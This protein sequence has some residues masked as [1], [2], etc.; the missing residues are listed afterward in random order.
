MAQKWPATPEWRAKLRLAMQEKGLTEATLATAVGCG[1][2]T[3]HRLLTGELQSSRYVPLI[4]RHL[5]ME[6]PVLAHLDEAKAQWAE[7]Y[8]Q[9]TPESREL[10]IK[11]IRQIK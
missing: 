6:Q 8:D 1:Q 4:T 7:P 11:L 2:S 5:R 3:I 10:I 9:L